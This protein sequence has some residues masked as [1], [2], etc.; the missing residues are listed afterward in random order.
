MTTQNQLLASP[1][2]FISAQNGHLITTSLAISEAFEKEHKDILRK[3][4]SLDIPENFSSAHFC[5]HDQKVSTGKGAQRDS[6]IYRMTKDGFMLLVMGF[7][8]KK[9]M[10]VKIAYINAFNMMAEELDR[11]QKQAAQVKQ[12][13]LQD[14]AAKSAKENELFKAAPK[15][16]QEARDYVCNVLEGIQAFAHEHN[17]SMADWVPVDRDKAASGLLA[18]LLHGIRA[19]L[20]FNMNLEPQFKLLPAGAVNIMPTDPE[21]MKAIVERVVSHDVLTAMMQAGISRLSS[22]ENK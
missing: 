22:G 6:K 18:D 13:Q 17:I 11:Q 21:C 2:H 3:I 15:Y 19:E 12:K 1:E 7:T 20:T 10:A 5:A 9:A 14:I 4:E 16:R 8:G